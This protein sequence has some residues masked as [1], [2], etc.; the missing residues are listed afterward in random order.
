M[1]TDRKVN[2]TLDFSAI[3]LWSISSYIYSTSIL[4]IEISKFGQNLRSN[5]MYGK[6][7]ETERILSFAEY[8][9]LIAFCFYSHNWF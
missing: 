3:I 6:N 4:S 8:F 1:V 7:D 5:K 2:A 9:V